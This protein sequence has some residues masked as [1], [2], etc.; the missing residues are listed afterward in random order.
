MKESVFFEKER[1]TGE[2]PARWAPKNKEHN[3]N[4]SMGLEM[5]MKE[6][7]NNEKKKKVKLFSNGSGVSEMYCHEGNKKKKEI[8]KKGRR[9]E[10]ESRE[11]ELTIAGQEDTRR[12]ILQRKRNE[13]H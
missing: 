5:T 8:L 6:G 12:E 10:K 7:N 2:H 11:K 3:N 13:T 4:N 9:A 1:E